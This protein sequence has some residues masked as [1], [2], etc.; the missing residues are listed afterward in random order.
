MPDKGFVVGNAEIGI[1]SHLSLH[2]FGTNRHRLEVGIV[3]E[4]A[5]FGAYQ[6]GEGT[7]QENDYREGGPGFGLGEDV[8]LLFGEGG[9]LGC[10]LGLLAVLGLL[11]A[12][13]EQSHE[14]LPASTQ[15]AHHVLGCA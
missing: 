11:A 6:E 10:G 2:I 5:A 12:A 15:T 7:V 9:L 3:V 13:A 4:R 14:G 1:Q 8:A